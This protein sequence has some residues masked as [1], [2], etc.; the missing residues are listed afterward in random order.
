MANVI[1]LRIDIYDSVLCL[2]YSGTAERLIA[3]FPQTT[4]EDDWAEI[5]E[6]QTLE[7]F[8][9]SKEMPGE[10][11]ETMLRQLRTKQISHGP[12]LRFSLQGPDDEKITRGSIF[13]WGITFRRNSEFTDEA[14]VQ[15][16]Q[17][18]NSFG[19]GEV[20]SYSDED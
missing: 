4:F 10:Q 19:V 20:E 14:T 16:V 15:L 13:R 9:R 11:R 17:F 3:A 6:Y 8:V 1:W 18:L 2:A 12:T 5:A 7:A